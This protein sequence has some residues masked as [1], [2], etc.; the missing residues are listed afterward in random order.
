MSHNAV[1][2]RFAAAAGAMGAMGMIAARGALSAQAAQE[3]VPH[4]T[5]YPVSFPTGSTELHKADHETIHGVAAM[6]ERNP[7]LN[8][9]VVG[10]ADA[11]GSAEY[12]E[13]LSW[14]RAAAVFEALVFK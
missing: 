10:K 12:N 4:A 3:E 6:M 13:H 5:I 11:V 2:R 14:R 9:T 7:A 1:T 8:A